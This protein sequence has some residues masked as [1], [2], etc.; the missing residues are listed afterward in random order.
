V[1]SAIHRIHLRR[2]SVPLVEVRAAA[3]GAESTRESIL[4]EV[5]DSRGASGWGECVALAR[6]TYTGE[7]ISGAWSVLTGLVAPALV[8]GR[9]IAIVGHPMAMA[10]VRDALLDLELRRA[11][12]SLAAHLGSAERVASRAVIGLLGDEESVVSA[13]ASRVDDGHRSVKLKVVPGAAGRIV[14]RVRER[15]PDLDLAADANGSFVLDRDA[16]E[17]AVLDEARLTYLEQ[18]LGA[19]DLVG[20]AELRRR[21][22]TPIALDESIDSVG[23]LAT[24]HALGAVD[25]VNVK[26]GRLGGVEATRR[27]LDEMAAR[28]LAGFCGGMYELG[29]GRATALAVAASP[30]LVELP[31]DLGPSRTYVEHDIAAPF[32]LDPDGCIDVPADMGI[33]RVPDSSRLDEVTTDHVAIDHVTLGR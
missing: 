28:S 30:T 7:W 18:P 9:E 11:R 3:H 15:W 13:V 29:I 22:E 4:V 12:R 23:T 32:V 25:L 27:L 1:T 10:A 8:A 24:A 33:G 16:A 21:F 31:C 19:Q 2:L 5:V 14:G 20:H 17:L 26:P 6:P